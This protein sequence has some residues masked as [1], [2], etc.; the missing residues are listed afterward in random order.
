MQLDLEA[1][2]SA[3]RRIG[4]CSAYVQ[5]GGGNTSLKDDHG[6]MAIKASGTSLATVEAGTG[7]IWL[8]VLK[9]REGLVD[10]DNETTYAALL[11]NCVLDARETRRPSIESGFHAL[12]GA[13]TIHTHSVWVNLL[14]CSQ[15]GRAIA[16][17][18]LPEALWVDYATPGIALTHL[19]AETM[20]GL[21]P[22]VVLLQN[23]G[24]VVTGSDPETTAMLHEEVN[25]KV[26]DAFGRDLPFPWSDDVAEGDENLL[27]P[28]QAVYTCDPTLRLSQAGVETRQAVSF[29]LAAMRSLNLS[30][31][32]LSEAERNKLI[33]LESEK[34]RQKMVRS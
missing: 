3:S 34:Y 11:K 1:L 10:C 33:G 28:D 9:L 2:A 16:Q 5:G 25:R 31:H 19:V 12:M 32:F 14:T 24:L 26:I 4:T 27:F 30:P 18:I 13:C 22:Q 8:D 6:R 15:E 21:R 20:E 7:F 23:H 17:D 29:L